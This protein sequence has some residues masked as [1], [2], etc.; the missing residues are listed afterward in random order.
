ML[1]YSKEAI[2]INGFNLLFNLNLHLTQLSESVLLMEVSLPN[3]SPKPGNSS[4][5]RSQDKVKDLSTEL[6]FTLKEML[7]FLVHKEDRNPRLWLA[8]FHT[9]MYFISSH[10]GQLHKSRYFILY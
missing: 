8:A 9:L 4:Q 2:Q 7:L 3:L 10:N 6:F 1:N 5:Q